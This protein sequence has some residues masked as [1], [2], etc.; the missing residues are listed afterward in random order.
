MSKK[1]DEIFKTLE[2]LKSIQSEI[3]EYNKTANIRELEDIEFNMG[4]E[5]KKLKFLF[6]SLYSYNGK[7][8]SYAKRQASK[9]NGKKGGRPPKEITEVKKRL[10]AIDNL[11]PELQHNID[12]SDDP[13]E[14]AKLE[15]EIAALESEKSSIAMK[16]ASYYDRDL[17][18][19]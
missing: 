9:E 12:L 10:S 17:S 13:A 18:N 19:K 8:T 1:T 4:Q 2:S 15:N 3:S 11:I 7:S 5:L 6:E 14:L 16:L